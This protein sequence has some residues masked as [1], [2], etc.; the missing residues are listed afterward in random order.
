MQIAKAGLETYGAPK[1][2]FEPL[3]PAITGLI[4][5]LRRRYPGVRPFDDTQPWTFPIE[6]T[7]PPGNWAV[8]IVADTGGLDAAFRPVP[9][10]PGVAARVLCAPGPP[11]IFVAGWDGKNSTARAVS[12][13]IFPE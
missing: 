7:A 4:A 6:D 11:R 13:R 1:I 10:I 3:R 8:T 12:R 2:R 5:I 9:G